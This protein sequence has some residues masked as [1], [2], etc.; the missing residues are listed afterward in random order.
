MLPK[1]GLRKKESNDE[2]VLGDLVSHVKSI[3]QTQSALR[4]QVDN[5]LK[6]LIT[7]QEIYF[8]DS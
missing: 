6:V 2:T 8:A 5:L 3:E 7:S 4:V 1:G